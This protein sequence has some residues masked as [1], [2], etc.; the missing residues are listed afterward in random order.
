MDP[1]TIALGLRAVLALAPALI[2]EYEQ[3]KRAGNYTPEERA[4]LDAQIEGYKTKKN[5]QE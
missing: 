1:A 5:W 3:A 4:D 2:A